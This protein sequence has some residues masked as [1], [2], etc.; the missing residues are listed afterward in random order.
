LKNEIDNDFGG[1]QLNDFHLL[2]LSSSLH[3]RRKGYA[4]KSRRECHKSVKADKKQGHSSFYNTAASA[5]WRVPNLSNNIAISQVHSTF[6]SSKQF[7]LNSREKMQTNAVYFDIIIIN[8]RTVLFKRA[9]N[10]QN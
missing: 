1:L 7:L 10:A 4:L 2:T 5:P 9:R 8:L 6:M 3:P